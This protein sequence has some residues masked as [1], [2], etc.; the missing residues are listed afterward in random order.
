MD[1][2]GR[3]KVLPDLSIPGHPEVRVLG[4]M[5]TLTDPKGQVV[6]G[7]SPAAI[8]MGEYTAKNI[9]EEIRRGAVGAPGNLRPFVYFDKGTMATIGR[10]RAVAKIGRFEFSGF[11]AW[12]TWLFVHLIFLI[13]FRNKVSVLLSWVYSYW[14]FKRGARVI[15]GAASAARTDSAQ[16]P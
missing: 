14:T 6:P 2:G 16:P 1:R 15:Y 11:P 7:V 10:S 9:A 3:V 5:I 8:Q 4:D 13:G 12:L